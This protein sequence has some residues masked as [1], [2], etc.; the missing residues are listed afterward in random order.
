LL[1]IGAD[2]FKGGGLEGSAKVIVNNKISL[3]TEN[4]SVCI[5][6][7]ATHHVERPG[8]VPLTWNELQTSK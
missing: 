4:Q 7:G 3:I 5:L 1:A 2:H 6:L 8:K